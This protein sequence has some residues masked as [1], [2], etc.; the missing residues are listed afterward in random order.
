MS[1]IETATSDSNGPRSSRSW[2]FLDASFGI[3]SPGAA[4][5]LAAKDGT[6]GAGTDSGGAGAIGAGAATIPFGGGGGTEKTIVGAVAGALGGK[7]IGRKFGSRL[8]FRDPGS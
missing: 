8:E 2:G 6:G 5:G 4:V 7:V 1:V 3:G